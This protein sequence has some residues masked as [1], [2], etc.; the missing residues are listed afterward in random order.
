MPTPDLDQTAALFGLL[1][2]P[3]RLAVLVCLLESAPRS[4]SE[5]V[6]AT[7]S[8]RTALSHQLRRLREGR[9]VRRQ[10]KG[11]RHLYELA[12]HHVAHIVRDALQHVAEDDQP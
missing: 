8:E 4:V 9:L 5:L 1:A 11:R 10:R 6:A 12:D 7:G 2:H 3:G